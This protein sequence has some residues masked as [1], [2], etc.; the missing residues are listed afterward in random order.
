MEG[1]RSPEDPDMSV[2]VGATTTRAQAKREAAPK[3]LRVPD[4][5]R[6]VG[7]DREQLIKLQ[8]RIQE[9][10]HWWMLEGLPAAGICDVGSPR[11]YYWS[12]SWDQENER[13]GPEQLLLAWGRWRRDDVLP[14]V[15][16]RTVKKGTV[17][18]VPLE[19]VPLTHT[20]F[21]RVAIDLR[22]P[23]NPPSEAGHRFIL[24][25]VDYATRFAEAVPLHKI[26]TESVVDI[27]SRLGVPEEVLSGS[28]RSS[29]QIA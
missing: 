12:A 7:V 6:H 1:A 2:M 8:K 14:V 29:Y 13:Q 20:P 15:C 23:V 17:P 10:W 18:R 5:E 25:L 21:K 19:Q 24:T 27:Y 26:D 9:Y 16:Q 3:P 11:F 4:I 28:E 22:G